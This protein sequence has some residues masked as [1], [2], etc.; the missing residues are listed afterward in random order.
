LAIVVVSGMCIFH[1]CQKEDKNPI[2]NNTEPTEIKPNDYAARIEKLLATTEIDIYKLSQLKEV[3]KEAARSQNMM[4]RLIETS[5]SKSCEFTESKLNQLKFYKT[6]M[7]VARETNDYPLF[8]TYL[9]YSNNVYRLICDFTI[10]FYDDFF[11]LDYAY[12]PNIPDD[13]EGPLLSFW[14]VKRRMRK[15]LE[16]L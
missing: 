5:D 12:N 10:I 2:E 13:P 14:K 11:L 1:A 9:N 3:Q 8:F 7:D 16:M 4:N 6:V 15:Y